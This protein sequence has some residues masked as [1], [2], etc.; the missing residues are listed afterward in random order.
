M[1]I[2]TVTLGQLDINEEQIYHFPKGIPGFESETD[3]AV[4]ELQEGPFSYL[5]SLKTDTLALLL[6]D[7][8]LFYKSYEFELPQSEMEELAIQTSVQVRA[9]V[10]IKEKLDESTLNLLAPIVF[11]PDKRIAKQVVLHRSDY[12]TKQLLWKEGQTKEGEPS[13]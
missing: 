9:V 10:T 4:I 2:E 1:L 12:S 6:T 7:P 8:F 13:C 5:Q 3:F 11:N